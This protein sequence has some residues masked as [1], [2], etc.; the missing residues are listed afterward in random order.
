MNDIGME[1]WKNIKRF[2]GLYQISN[3]GNVR[4]LN[5]KRTHI[6]KNMRLRLNTNRYLSVILRNNNKSYPLMIH[7]IVAESFIPNPNN[8]KEVNHKDE[9]KTNNR[10][11][12]LEWCTSKYNANYGTRN[13]RVALKESK[14]V[15]GTNI[16]TGEKIFFKSMAEATRNGFRHVSE[17]CSNKVKQDK[18]YKWEII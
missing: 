16:N 12:N 14:P 3:M 7:R 9:D 4:S 17:C 15:K 11:D 18:G 1:E 8:Y 2:E 5:Y 10:T 13:I 6:I